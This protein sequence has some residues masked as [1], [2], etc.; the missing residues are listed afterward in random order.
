M[1]RLQ[2]KYTSQIRP[3]LGKELAINNSL[4][5]PRLEKI[6]INAGVGRAVMDS[7]HI[8]PV[9]E[10]ITAIAGQKPVVTRSKKSIAT[11]KLRDNMPIGVMVTLRGERMYTFLDLL[12]SVVLPR[13]RDFRGLSNMSFDKSGNYNI[14]IADHTVFPQAASIEVGQP[15]GV[16]ITLVTK[17]PNVEAAKALLLGLGVPLAKE[18]K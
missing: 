12:N 6:V 1:N 5:V 11:F 15:V 13:L 3:E 2:E 17:T 7:K 4:A 18:A 9:V 8:D 10:V 14:G 16:Q